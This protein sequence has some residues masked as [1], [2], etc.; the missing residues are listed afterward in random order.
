ME[1][2]AR[3]ERKIVELSLMVTQYQ[4]A[5]QNQPPNVRQ[6]GPMPTSFPTSSEL[7]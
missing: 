4:T 2:I 5:F 1:V 3:L 7:D 6:E